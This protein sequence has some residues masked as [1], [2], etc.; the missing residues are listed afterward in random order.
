MPPKI[1]DIKTCPKCGSRRQPTNA[2]Y[3]IPAYLRNDPIEA[4]STKTATPVR[5]VVCPNCDYVEFFLDRGQ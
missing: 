3:G 2:T 5:M 4:I 1:E